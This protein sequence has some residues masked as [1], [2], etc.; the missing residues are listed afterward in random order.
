MAV[1][2]DARHFLTPSSGAAMAET[3]EEPVPRDGA[4]DAHKASHRERSRQLSLGPSAQKLLHSTWPWA[5][6]ASL[7]AEIA[8]RSPGI[9]TPSGR[10]SCCDATGAPSTR[11]RLRVQSVTDSSSIWSDR[12]QMH[13]RYAV[14][15]SVRWHRRPGGYPGLTLVVFANQSPPTHWMKHSAMLARG[16]A[17]DHATG[18]GRRLRVSVRRTRLDDGCGT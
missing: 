4:C 15:L 10:W 5:R 6:Q 12:S 2:P 13:V 17:D 1:Q 16:G 18:P 3:R 11:S 8:K 7:R 9:R 14:H